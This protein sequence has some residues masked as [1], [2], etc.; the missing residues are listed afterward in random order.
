MREPDL[1]ASQDTSHMKHTL[2]VKHLGRADTLELYAIA[3][4][5]QQSSRSFRRHL[6]AMPGTNKRR[7]VLDVH[8]VSFH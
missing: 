8:N 5:L 1:Q 3:V 4:C 7:S 6:P 2:R